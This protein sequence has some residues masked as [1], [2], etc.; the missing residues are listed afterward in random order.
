MAS[1]FHHLKRGWDWHHFCKV[2]TKPNF[3]CCCQRKTSLSR[4]AEDS[5][6]EPQAQAVGAARSGAHSSGFCPICT[7]NSAP[8][9]LDLQM[10]SLSVILAVT[11]LMTLWPCWCLC[12]QAFVS[13]LPTAVGTAFSLGRRLHF[14]QIPFSC[15]HFEYFPSPIILLWPRLSKTKMGRLLFLEHFFPINGGTDAYLALT[16]G[17]SLQGLVSYQPHHNFL[18]SRFFQFFNP[19]RLLPFQSLCPEWSSP[20]IPFA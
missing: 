6:H 2:I 15:W 10:T 5:C 16:T 7:A 8:I 14:L 17:Q 13:V 19:F 1:L 20:L 12:S 18:H 9:V 11:F 4:C 3:G